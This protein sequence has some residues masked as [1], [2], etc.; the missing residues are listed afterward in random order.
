MVTPETLDTILDKEGI[1][2]PDIQHEFLLK[3]DLCNLKLLA[4][5]HLEDDAGRVEVEIPG[6]AADARMAEADARMTEAG[7]R[8]PVI[9]A[10]AETA[11]IFSRGLIHD[12]KSQTTRDNEDTSRKHQI[13]TTG[14]KDRL[15]R[16]A[17]AKAAAAGEATVVEPPG[18]V[19]GSSEKHK[20]TG[21]WRC[22][23]NYGCGQ[24]NEPGTD[25]CRLC[26]S[27]RPR[28]NP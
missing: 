18:L 1:I 20:V 16:K 23:D 6:K 12:L 8:S 19:V 22:M 28:D 4:S 5:P 21:A 7:E 25:R 14:L 17:K 2:T 3:V 10:S 24:W 13:A 15:G 26:S 9:D 11:A 27:P